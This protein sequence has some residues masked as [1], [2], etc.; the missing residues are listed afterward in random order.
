MKINY[1]IAYSVC[2]FLF[3]VSSWVVG[4]ESFVLKGDSILLRSEL[5]LETTEL[6]LNN[7]GMTK[8]PVNLHEFENLKSISL[9]N[10]ALIAIDGLSQ[11]L[12][13][14]EIDLSKNPEL[15]IGQ[16]ATELV[17]IKSLAYL[18]LSGCGLVYL[19]H[20]LFQ[21]QELKHLD[22][23]RNELSILPN[24]IKEL[25]EL[26]WLDLSFNSLEVVKP[27][28]KNLS[29]LTDLNLGNNQIRNYE[30]L[31]VQLSVINGLH[32]L[33]MDGAGSM[34]YEA[35][36]LYQIRK[37]ILTNLEINK[38]LP[39]GSLFPNLSSM[40]IRVEVTGDY[41]AYLKGFYTL[42]KLNELTIKD[43]DLTVL[44][45]ELTKI[46]SLKSISIY[47][48]QFTDFPAS[49]SRLSQLKS[50]RVSG[51]NSVNQS[52]LFL[53]LSR[54]QSLENLEIINCDLVEI[55]E[56]VKRL[57]LL[58]R[59]DFSGNSLTHLPISLGE[60]E[61]LELLQVNNNQVIQEDILVIEVLNPDL[62]IE[63]NQS[64][65]RID[66]VVIPPVPSIN[67]L[68]ELFNVSAQ[69]SQR[70]ETASGT[71]IRIPENAFLYAN[72]E[73]V[74]GRVE[75][76][77]REFSD[78]L[79][80]AFA[81]IPMTFEKN[82]EF[83]YFSSA[84]MMAF[85]A[86]QKG[87]AVFY[88]PESVIEVDLVSNNPDPEMDLFYLDANQQEWV[89]IGK[90]RISSRAPDSVDRPEMILPEFPA[91]PVYPKFPYK[92]ESIYLSVKGNK[93]SARYEIT[94]LSRNTGSVK[95]G[96]RSATHQ[97]YSELKVLNKSKWM[98]DGSKKNRKIWAKKID[99]IQ[100]EIGQF[101]VLNNRSNRAVRISD[102]ALSNAGVDIRKVV[103]KEPN[104]LLEDVWIE[105]NKKKDNFSLCLDLSGVIVK[106]PVL[107]KRSYGSPQ[108]VQKRFAS[109]YTNYSRRLKERRED[110]AIVEQKSAE[111]LL[112]YETL[113][114]MYSLESKNYS[115][116]LALYR[117]NENKILANSQVTL[118][119]ITRS[120]RI[121]GFGYYN[122]DR[123][124]RME[125]PEPLIARLKGSEDERMDPTSYVVLDNT[126]NTIFYYGSQ[127]KIRYEKGH[128][129]SLLLFL[130][131]DK[132]AVFCGT[133]GFSFVDQR[134]APMYLTV[135]D[136]KGMTLQELKV[137]T[138]LIW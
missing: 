85:N 115:K 96:K 111:Y 47:G 120:F 126:K 52:A 48:F 54:L 9:Q 91:L 34:E 3:M 63:Y 133:Q 109:T 104:Y 53:K 38:S 45:H 114:D 112:E 23:S 11:L 72:G 73:I 49:L 36:K 33:T 95:P 30:F 25:H 80:M 74:T 2:S 97:V 39:V 121:S 102:S 27:G 137:K 77:Y 60:L 122:C 1:S 18:D 26:T 119:N 116:M 82:G 10:N 138:G 92:K 5:I 123:I 94:V 17:Q 28:I 43:D 76:S 108:S 124:F 58:K 42:E 44:T 125:N 86:S 65:K 61:S 132:V 128:A 59:I 103:N 134:N 110:W 70:I 35:L 57:H 130:P 31:L 71:R 20:A 90:D 68:P 6:N 62:K 16:V 113:M 78:P 12:R 88:N 32:T 14:E 7:L 46:K 101:K 100:K 106:I 41:A 118:S 50:L 55:D 127:S 51:S 67:V 99:S 56:S 37:L 107:P 93:K 89:N 136:L 13:L 8:L 64:I 117:A 83:N 81:G 75:V 22:L 98:I 24:E 4:Q 29:K 21:N 79:D 131:D 69:S 129:N 19:P 66:L 40:E 135:Y 84:G 87:E 105:P 15:H